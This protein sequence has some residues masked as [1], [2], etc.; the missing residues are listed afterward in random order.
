MG[1]RS[2]VVYAFAFKTREQIEEVLAI[3]QMH[4]MVQKHRLAE[5]WQIHEWDAC[6]G[7]TYHAE[8]VKWYD[9]YED[10]IGIN[11][12]KNVVDDFVEQRGE[13]VGPIDNDG[14]Q[15]VVVAF[16]Y[17]YRMLRIGE[18]DTDIENDSSSNSNLDE[19]LWDRL[20][21]RREIETDF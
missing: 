8:S 19:A 7:L 3:Y 5:V 6:W 9:G 11:H 12:M 17:A 1:Y 2:D 18:D 10:V 14:K 20:S 13:D 4:P 21:L 15:E 16:P